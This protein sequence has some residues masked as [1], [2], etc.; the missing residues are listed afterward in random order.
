ME[1]MILLF[2]LVTLGSFISSLTGL[3]GGSLILA[4][5]LLVYPP[6]LAIPLHAFTQFSANALR[7]GLYF[8]KV[9]WKV[10]AA[11][12]SLM[13]VGAWSGALIFEHI[14]SSW[15]KILVGSFII[16]SLIPFKFIPKDVPRMRT[17]VFLGA[18]S[19]FLGIF[20]GAVGPLVT[21]FFNRLK[22]DR[23]GMIATKSA[24]Q[25]ILQVSKIL[26]FGGAAGINFSG[27]KENIG[28]LVLG[29]ILGVALSIPVGNK[30]SDEKFDKAVNIM[31]ALISIKVLYEGIGELFF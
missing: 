19:G 11:Y 7:A 6:E 1:S 15:L 17:F 27:L 31:L 22:I 8:K 4:G 3:G 14:N 13:M 12:G 23:N 18:F 25:M 29:T 5:L 20:V 2:A 9:N 28:L 26:A 16:L 10:V 24:G 30:I 21:P